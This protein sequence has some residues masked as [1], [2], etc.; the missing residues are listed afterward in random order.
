MPAQVPATA[1]VGSTLPVSVLATDDQGGTVT[2]RASVTVYGNGALLVQAFDDSQGLPCTDQAGIATVEGGA[3]QALDGNG[4][5]ALATALPQDWIVVQKPGFT[6]VWR[7]TALTAGAVQTAV[8]ARLT[9]LAPSQRAD[10]GA[11]TGS[12]G[13]GVLSLSLP[14]AAADRPGPAAGGGG[15]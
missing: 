1:A 7:S 10:G 13:G 9:P 12:F 4:R 6:P 14:G 5:A 11:F 15:G 2:A 3:A 8:S